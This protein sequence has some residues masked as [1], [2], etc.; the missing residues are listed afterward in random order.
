VH[1]DFTP[2]S[3]V[4][5]AHNEEAVIARCLTTLQA[6][7][8]EGELDIIV[9]CNGCQDATAEVARQVAPN[10][11]VIEV[12]VASKV[13]ALN[14]GDRAASYFPR[15]YVDADVELPLPD[16]RR[17]ARAL[18][19]DGILCAAPKPMF[20]LEHRSWAIRAFYDV[21]QET[22]YLTEDMIGC[23]VYALSEQGRARFEEFPELTADDQFVQQLFDRSE[24]KAV[25]GAQFAVQAPRN[26]RGLLA[27]RT[28]AYRGKIELASSGLA[29]VG[30]PAFGAKAALRK[31]RQPTQGPAV[32]VY[33]SVNILAKVLAR[34]SAHARWERDDSARQF[35][36]TAFPSAA[37][38]LVDREAGPIVCYVTSHYPAVSHT[39]VMREIMGVRA[40]GLV[41]ET[42]SVHKADPGQL[43]AVA[44]QEEAART[45]NILP[46]DRPALA[47]AHLRAAL[48][49]PR[50]YFYTLGQALSSAPPGLRG[51]LWQLFY[52]AEAVA[53][54]DHAE[55]LGARHLHAHLANV[56]AD[57]AWLA[58]A[59][60]KAAQPAKRWSWSFTMHG[61]TELYST[62]RFN[63]ARKV[64][65]A[66]AVVCISEYTRSQLM[67]LSEPESWGKLQ[68]VHCGV[69]T[70]RY[71]Y[72]TPEHGASLSVLCVCRLVPAKGLDVLV[73][74]VAALSERGTEVRLV[75]VGSGPL[76]EALRSKTRKLG[77]EGQVFFEGAVGQDDIAR[78][79]ADADVFCLPSFA[80]GL[81][82]V[83]MEAMATGRPVVA[84]RITGIPELVEDGV[85]GFLVAPGS[86]EQ[87]VGALERLAASPELREQMGLAGRQKVVE[88]FDARRCA[89][90][91]ADI[92]KSIASSSGFGGLED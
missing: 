54:W 84:T 87:L 49:H 36:R 68:V 53:L 81:P 89:G 72:V 79:Y 74:A 21:W 46:L 82:V 44:D 88:A 26:F 86:V 66:D 19:G 10:A 12:P 31:A 75:L 22:P 50:A 2:V 24:R 60:G 37:N 92:F 63:L 16:L 64:A 5:P 73:G 57:V 17:V 78:Y 14:A 59:F 45:W 29:R 30:A 34:K 38:N 48:R 15:F 27:M 11:T 67:Y 33:A 55:V 3:V 39:F 25:E 90:Q 6:G 91:V 43:L 13:A 51:H 42:V 65:N 85:S 56:A 47:R 35:A 8:G 4:I 52:F 61:P 23:G 69:D 58:S 80:E 18:A 9:V 40:C 1:D 71:C 20:V 28:R 32:A 41:V 77:L 70:E 83:L 7:A 76:E 62:E